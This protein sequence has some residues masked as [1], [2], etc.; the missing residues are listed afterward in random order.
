MSVRLGLFN[1][2]LPITIDRIL[3]GSLKSGGAKSALKSAVGGGGYEQTEAKLSIPVKA[4]AALR[5][6]TQ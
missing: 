2:F 6:L 4:E 5:A 1:P 3:H